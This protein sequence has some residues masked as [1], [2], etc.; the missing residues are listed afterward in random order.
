MMIDGGINIVETFICIVIAHTIILVLLNLGFV[1]KSLRIL[2]NPILLIKFIFILLTFLNFENLSLL[3]TA[4][5]SRLGDPGIECDLASVGF[6]GRTW[7]GRRETGTITADTETFLDLGK[8]SL[9]T[10]CTGIVG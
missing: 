1:L 4:V 10:V 3:G 5:G 9:S 8:A 6:L 7:A 2:L